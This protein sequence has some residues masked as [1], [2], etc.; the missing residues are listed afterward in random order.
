MICGNKACKFEFC[1]LCLKES[2]P[3][4]YEEGPCSGMQFIDPDSFF[5]RLEQKYPIL[6]YVFFFFKMILLIIGFC[7]FVCF[8]AL[9]LWI[10]AGF[11]LNENF[12]M[13]D[14]D[15]DK[16][17][18]LSKSLSIMHYIIC[19]PILLSVQSVFYFS[20]AIVMIVLTFYTIFYIFNGIYLLF[21][22][23]SYCCH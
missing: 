12:L 10:L 19:I 1:W 14:D 2:L 21:I 13:N 5:Y 18:V 16:L 6:Y 15:E 7:L 11:I 3:G 8:P 20:L 22:L 9:A 23:C 17:F 4:H